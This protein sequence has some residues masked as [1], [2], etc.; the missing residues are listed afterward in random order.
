MGSPPLKMRSWLFAPGDSEK[1]MRRAAD[2]AADVALLEFE[3]AVTP[4]KKGLARTLVRDFLD[5]VACAGAS[6]QR[7]AMMPATDTA[8]PDL[9]AHVIRQ[10]GY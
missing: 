5:E 7:R 10:R 6:R 9:A 1:K 8:G 4:E 2:S 3:D